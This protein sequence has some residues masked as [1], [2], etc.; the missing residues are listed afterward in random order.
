MAIAKLKL[1]IKKEETKEENTCNISK[2]DSVFAIKLK[3]ATAITKGMD[4]KEAAKLLKISDYKLNLLRSDPEFEEFVEMCQA[5]C[6]H[7]HLGNINLAGSLGAWQASA[8]ILERKFPDKY[9]KKDIVRHE[10]EMKFMSFQKIILEVIN[11]LDP[12][13]KHQVMKKLRQVDIAEEI[14]N[15]QQIE[16]HEKQTSGIA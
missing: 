15:L 13:L 10:Y 14:G 16:Y 7:R 1:K 8:W 5:Q 3:L 2:K 6:E 9:G 12:H 11:S 4:I